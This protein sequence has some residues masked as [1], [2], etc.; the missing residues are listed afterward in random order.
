MDVQ[1]KCVGK[2][3]GPGFHKAARTYTLDCG[4]DRFWL[5]NEGEWGCQLASAINVLVDDQPALDFDDFHGC[6]AILACRPNELR[7]DA[8]QLQHGVWLTAPFA[9]AHRT[10]HAQQNGCDSK[11]GGGEGRTRRL[12]TVVQEW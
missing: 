9:Y 4:I 1:E 8:V 2:G 6:R 11:N 3:R 12:Y 10:H 7:L 5:H